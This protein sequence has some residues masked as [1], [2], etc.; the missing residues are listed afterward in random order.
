MQTADDIFAHLNGGETF[1]KLDL[2]L[3]CQQVL[4]DEE[5]KQYIIIYTHLGLFQY[6]CLRFGV[7]L[8][9]AI[10]QKIVDSLTQGLKGVSR[11]L[12]N[13]IIARANDEEHLCNLE[14][15]LNYLGSMAV[16]LRKEKCPFMKPL[17]Q[18]FASLIFFFK[19]TKS[20]YHSSLLTLQYYTYY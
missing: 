19:Q 7:S 4:L 17:V 3:A 12:D 13:L 15:T 2:S 20:F 8:S 11:I 18:Y 9:L 5:S 6:I 10:I 16:K 14:G 1:S